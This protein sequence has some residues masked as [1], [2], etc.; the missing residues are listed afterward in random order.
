MSWYV[1]LLNLAWWSPLTEKKMDLSHNHH[2]IP[3]MN[4]STRSRIPRWFWVLAKPLCFALAYP[5]RSG[6]FLKWWWPIYYVHNHIHDFCISGPPLFFY[7]SLHF[8]FGFS[9]SKKHEWKIQPLGFCQPLG[10]L[11][12]LRFWR[13]HP[14]MCQEGSLERSPPASGATGFFSSS[15]DRKLSCKLS[16]FLVYSSRIVL[17]STS[18][19]YTSIMCVLATSKYLFRGKSAVTGWMFITS[20][21]YRTSILESSGRRA[22]TIERWSWR[23]SLSYFAGWPST[24]GYQIIRF[25]Y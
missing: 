18:F 3:K 25:G 6:D 21:D 19:Y 7:R 17:L 24:H 4:G 11:T 16:L 13:Y 20:L 12:I 5:I 22:G 8:I 1:A 2:A 23:P 14:C 10:K 15:K 9:R